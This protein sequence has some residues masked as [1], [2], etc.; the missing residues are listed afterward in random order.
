MSDDAF[1]IEHGHAEYEAAELLEQAQANAQA[2]LLGT[3]AFLRD[4]GIGGG[5]WAAALGESFGKGWGEPRPWE[6]AEFLDAM[7]TNYRALGAEVLAV[8]LGAE[9]A[10]A[11]LGPFPDPDLCALVGVAPGL[12][13]AFHDAP[14]AIA[15]PRGLLWRWVRDGADMHLLVERAEGSHLIGSAGASGSA[16]ES[17]HPPTP[18]PAA[19]GEGERNASAGREG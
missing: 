17:P 15:A 6:A 5:A 2:L 13:D 19:A 12:A 10:E 7:L 18:S 8:R 9:L 3:V 1:E 11:T 16:A 4:Q 14:A